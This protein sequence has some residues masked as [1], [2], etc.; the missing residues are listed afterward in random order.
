MI[1]SAFRQSPPPA[2]REWSPWA[3]NLFHEFTPGGDPAGGV[4]GAGGFA[5]RRASVGSAADREVLSPGVSP[6]PSE[7]SRR[8][9]LLEQPIGHAHSPTTTTTTISRA[10]QL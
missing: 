1:G 9:R 10:R 7:A 4:A 8:S 2:V 6:S 3:I 5:G